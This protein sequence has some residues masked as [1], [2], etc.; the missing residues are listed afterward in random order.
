M[1]TR[2]ASKSS[3]ILLAGFSVINY[4]NGQEKTAWSADKEDLKKAIFFNIVK[5]FYFFLSLFC[6]NCTPSYA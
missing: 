6:F 1:P 4:L 3:V 5:L 2:G